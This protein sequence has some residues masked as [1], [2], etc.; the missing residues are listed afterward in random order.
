MCI[1]ISAHAAIGLFH[2]CLPGIIAEACLHARDLP[3]Q[4]CVATPGAGLHWRLP[5]ALHIDVLSTWFSLFVA[6]IF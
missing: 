5:E 3:L 1:F 2:F 6:T 4:P